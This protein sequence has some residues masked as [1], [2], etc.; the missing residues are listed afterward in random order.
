MRDYINCELGSFNQICQYL[1]KPTIPAQAALL[2]SSHG[3]FGQNFVGGSIKVSEMP[4]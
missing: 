4:L 2:S 3:K 1:G